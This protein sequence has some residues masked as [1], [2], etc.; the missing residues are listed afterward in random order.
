[1]A[2]ALPASSA[3]AFRGFLALI[4]SSALVTLDGTA[5]TVALPAIGRD[6]GGRFSVLQWTTNASLL[7]LAALVIPAGLLGDTYGRRRMM[8]LGLVLFAAASAGCALAPQA[9]W[10]IGLRFAQGTGAALIVP[11]AVA[12]LRAAYSDEHERAR[13]FGAWA[14]WSGA[15]SAVGPLAGGVLVDAFSWRAVF[16]LSVALAVPTLW[17]LRA[18]P[19]SRADGDRQPL[20]LVPTLL[21]VVLLAGSSFALIN[22][23]DAS[24]SS[25][26]T[27]A[28]LAGVGIAALAL[29]RYGRRCPVLPAEI[30]ASTNCLAANAATFV[31]YF[32]VFGSGFLLVI[33]TQAALGY[34]AT[35]SAVAVLPSAAMMLLLAEPFGRVTTRVGTRAILILAPLTAA[36]GLVWIGLAPQPLPLWTHIIPG[37]ALFGCGVAMALSPLTHLAVSSIPEHAAGTASGVHHATVRSAGLAAIAVLGSMAAGGLEPGH[38]SL[39]G[40]RHSMLVCGGVIAVGGVYAGTRV[41]NDQPGGLKTSGA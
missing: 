2:H 39:E 25:L 41:M 13:R 36:A 31:L 21:I 27:V 32:G 16:L 24:W 11:G 20:Q 28:A 3:V 5:V 14:G 23:P 12:I 1:M 4:L 17:L 40:F 29:W 10:L 22:G 19:E 26:S 15:A 9:A 7:A 35:W 34:S 38:L 33:Y 8:R 30:S 37:T 6:L 18:V